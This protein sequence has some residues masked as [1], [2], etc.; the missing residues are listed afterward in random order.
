MENNEQNLKVNV[1]VVNNI[2]CLH[3]YFKGELSYE[4]ALDAIDQWK[5][6]FQSHPNEKIP[7]IWNCLEMTGYKPLART[8]W[9]SA[10]KQMKDQIDSIWLVTSSTLIKSGAMLMSMMSSLKIKTVKNEDE[11]NIPFSNSERAVS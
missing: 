1:Q 4:T 6:Y 7:I 11:V 3:F 5:E 10:I 8:A 2:N 9:Q